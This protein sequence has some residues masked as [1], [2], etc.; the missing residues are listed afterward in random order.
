MQNIYTS[1]VI[2]G[3]AMKVMAVI[4][5][6][7]HLEDYNMIKH[8]KNF[9]GT[10]AGAIISLL[11]ALKYTSFEIKKIVLEC[12]EDKTL[13]NFDAEGIFDMMT[14]YGI[15]NGENLEKIFI[16]LIKRKYPHNSNMTFVEFAKATGNN[17]II[18]ASNLSKERAEYFSVNTTPTLSVAKAV[19]TSC[20]IPLMFCPV[21]INDDIYLDGG[22]YNNFPIDYFTENRLHDILG[23]NII[24]KNYQKYENFFQYMKFIFHSIISKVHQTSIN[25]DENNVIT[26]EFEDENNW[27]SFSDIS[28]SLSL[29]QLDSYIDMGY[30]E[31]R[32]KIKFE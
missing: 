31:A 17:L 11:L 21:N 32:S 1:I 3:G 24:C 8:I 26:L 7:R 20:S 18:C 2:A 9:V 5:V 27:F 23:I 16:K 10:S 22:L 30:N 6:I 25:N 15:N 28:I 4:G 12:L 19:M 14:S 13:T 29:E